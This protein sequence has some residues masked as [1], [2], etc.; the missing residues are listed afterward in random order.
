MRKGDNTYNISIGGKSLFYSSWGFHN[1]KMSKGI[2]GFNKIEKNAI[3]LLQFQ[4]L[5]IFMHIMYPLAH[6]LRTSNEAFFHAFLLE[7]TIWQDKFWGMWDIFEQF[8]STHFGES[9]V[10]VF[11]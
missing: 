3:Y 9:L 7:Q 10:H 6:G 5:R 8:I 2:K 1:A 4:F 11:H